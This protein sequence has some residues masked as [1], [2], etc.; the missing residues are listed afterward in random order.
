M[1]PHSIPDRF[2]RRQRRR[3]TERGVPDART[4]ALSV[5]SDACWK[6]NEGGGLTHAKTCLLTDGIDRSVLKG[7]EEKLNTSG[8]FG[9]RLHIFHREGKKEIGEAGVWSESRFRSSITAE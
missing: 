9:Q 8:A 3:K 4:A 5:K 2:K 1:W 7:R 6:S